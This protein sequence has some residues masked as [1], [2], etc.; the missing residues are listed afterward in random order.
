MAN[1]QISSRICD[2]W[3]AAGFVL[4]YRTALIA[5]GLRQRQRILTANR[6]DNTDSVCT[7]VDPCH[8]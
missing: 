2:P 5:R 7:L 8:P 4:S 3:R 6:T 1:V